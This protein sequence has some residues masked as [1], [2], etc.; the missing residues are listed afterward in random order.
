MT[1]TNGDLQK[2]RRSKIGR[3]AWFRVD[4]QENDGDPDDV[5]QNASWRARFSARLREALLRAGRIRHSVLMS[6][7]TD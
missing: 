5:L 1:M 2:A 6:M 7:F 4:D 3:R